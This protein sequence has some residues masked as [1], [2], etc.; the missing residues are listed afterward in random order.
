MSTF[1]EHTVLT[2]RTEICCDCGVHFAMAEHF[3]TERSTNGGMFYCPNGH[4]QHYTKTRVK[5]LQGQLDQKERELRASKCETLAERQ[6]REKS[7]SKLKRVN[8]GVCPCCQRHFVN[9]ARHMATKHPEAK[10]A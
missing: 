8:R 1:T 2:Y 6:L 5:I 7:E 4:P 10:S 9:L 3:Y